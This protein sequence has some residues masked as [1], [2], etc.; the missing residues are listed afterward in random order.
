MGPMM[1]QAAHA[2]TAVRASAITD[3]VRRSFFTDT[4]G[5]GRRISPLGHCADLL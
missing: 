4:G 1:A 5:N 3:P 2:A